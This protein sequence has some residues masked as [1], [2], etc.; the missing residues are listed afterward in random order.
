MHM[1]YRNRLARCYLGASNAG[2]RRPHPFTGF[3]QNDDVELDALSR[4]DWKSPMSGPYPILNCSLNLVGGHELAWQQRKAAS[5]VFTPRYCGYDFSDLPPGYCSTTPSKKEDLPAYASSHTPLTL[6][7][8]MAI[9]GAA[10]SPNMGYHTA[11]APAFL[12]TLFNIRLG[13]WIGNPR[14]K[15]GWFRSSPGWA[16]GRLVAEMFGLTTA[17]GRYVYLSDGGHFENLGI[18]ELVRRR[19]RFIM[20]CDAEED[21]EFAFE[22]LGNAIEKCRTDLGVDIELDVKSIR[23]R[24]EKGYSRAHCAVGRI[25]YD[26]TDPGAHAGTI[27]YLKSSLTGDEPTDVLHYAARVA[28]FP[29]EIR[30]INPLANRNSRVIARSG[31]TRRCVP[32][33]AW[34]TRK[35]SPT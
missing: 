28:A 4:A 33:F 11:P 25:R 18:F 23:E 3:D 27:L 34:M 5:F 12:M 16:L 30:W 29:H 14:H 15:K 10:A 9:S 21:G 22:G 26:E 2:L 35:S 24:N 7:T 1:M 19:C 6:A 31:I 32:S 20:V 8:A 17:E 13:W